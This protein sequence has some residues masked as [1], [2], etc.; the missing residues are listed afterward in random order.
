MSQKRSRKIF[1]H[2]F[3]SEDLSSFVEQLE[4]AY[5]SMLWE[6]DGKNEEDLDLLYNLYQS[7]SKIKDM[8]KR[9][10]FSEF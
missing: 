1:E 9:K 7:I 8:L 5:C 3:T 6:K 10:G 4:S 2:N